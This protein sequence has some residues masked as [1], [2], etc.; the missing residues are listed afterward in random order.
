MTITPIASQRIEIARLTRS[1]VAS[2]YSKKIAYRAALRNKKP[3]IANGNAITT[4]T[5]VSAVIILA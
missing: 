1:M 3:A 4:R 2:Y 5:T